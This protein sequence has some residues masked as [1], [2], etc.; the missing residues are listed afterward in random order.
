M[1]KLQ[2]LFQ[3][4]KTKIINLNYVVF[5]VAKVATAE[6]RIRAVVRVIAD[7]SKVWIQLFVDDGHFK[8]LGFVSECNIKDGGLE[9]GQQVDEYKY[10]FITTINLLIKDKKKVGK[11]M[12][13]APKVSKWYQVIFPNECVEAMQRRHLQRLTSAFALGY[14]GISG[15]FLGVARFSAI[16]HIDVTDTE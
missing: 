8:A 6:H 9:S 4:T 3:I 5:N 1:I 10:P 13:T 2:I 15:R 11:Y 16:H 14:T 7:A 12:K